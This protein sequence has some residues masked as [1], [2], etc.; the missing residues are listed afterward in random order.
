MTLVLRSSFVGNKI[1]TGRLH[2]LI[3]QAP[4]SFDAVTK[5]IAGLQKTSGTW[6][7]VH[8]EVRRLQIEGPPNAKFLFD[9][10]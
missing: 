1:C 10:V 5:G 8:F 4:I 2:R 7:Y 6:R 9:R 3:S